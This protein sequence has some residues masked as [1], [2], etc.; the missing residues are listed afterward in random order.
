[1]GVELFEVCFQV[2]ASNCKNENTLPAKTP[3]GDL[4]LPPYMGQYRVCA[5]FEVLPRS[6]LLIGAVSIVHFHFAVTGTLP[7][8]LYVQIL[9]PPDSKTP[10]HLSPLLGFAANA[11]GCFPDLGVLLWLHA[12][13]I[14]VETSTM[15]NEFYKSIL[16]HRIH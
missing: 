9:R 10:S 16:I 1:V 5:L 3:P 7:A 11:E 12:E 8:L 6:L 2:D 4:V 15:S 13:S 14:D